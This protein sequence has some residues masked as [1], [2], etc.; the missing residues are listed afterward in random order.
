MPVNKNVP[1]VT[2]TSAHNEIQI[3]PLPRRPVAPQLKETQAYLEDAKKLAQGAKT[4][5]ELKTALESFQGCGLKHT[6]MSTV[7]ADGNAEADIMLIGEAPGA[8]EDRQGLPFVG[9][10][11][12]L[13]DNMLYAIGKTRKDDF[14]I[15]NVIPW[16]PPGNR[17]PTSE[18]TRLCLPF[19]RRHIELKNPKVLIFV[20]ATA[21]KTLL[22]TKEGM[23][24]LRGK[25]FDYSVT[26]EEQGADP[27][28]DQKKNQTIPATVL[29]HPSY[30][31]RSPGQ[32]KHAWADLLKIKKAL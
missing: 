5:S 28:S 25:W 2:Q 7:F 31:L 8:D 27:L 18:E 29:F 21:A 24:K 20:G 12:Q 10:S 30:L 22:G 11:G 14:Y 4:L 6:A 23:S 13:L 26:E 3:T 1:D 16:R 32:K 19:I 9:T 15:A 17:P